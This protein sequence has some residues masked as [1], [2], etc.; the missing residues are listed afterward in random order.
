[1]SAFL[2]LLLLT[3]EPFALAPFLPVSPSVD[4]DGVVVVALGLP[5]PDGLDVYVAIIGE[6]ECIIPPEGATALY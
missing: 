2:D 5:G 4:E 3:P 1:M 6:L